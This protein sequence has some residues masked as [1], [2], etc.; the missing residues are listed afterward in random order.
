VGSNNFLSLAL[1]TTKVENKKQYR[2]LVSEAIEESS[3]E[4]SSPEAKKRLGQ[5]LEL[6]TGNSSTESKVSVSLAVKTALP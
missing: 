5:C 6:F 4:C 1:N 3:K 2:R